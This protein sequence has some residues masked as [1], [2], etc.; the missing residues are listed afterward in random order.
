MTTFCQKTWLAYSKRSGQDLGIHGSWRSQGDWMEQLGL[1]HS[2]GLCLW[3]PLCPVVMS[4]T[5]V[6][7]DL[8]KGHW[9]SHGTTAREM[10]LPWCSTKTRSLV[11]R[12][13]WKEKHTN[14]LFWKVN[15]AQLTPRYEWPGSRTFHLFISVNSL[16]YTID[17][18]VQQQQQMLRYHGDGCYRKPCIAM[19]T[20]VAFIHQ[21]WI[22]CSPCLSFTFWKIMK[23]ILVHSIIFH[24]F[25]FTW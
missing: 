14:N 15:L 12:E 11:T 21:N 17:K 18:S 25:L 9:L 3:S 1:V 2:W 13:L 20:M 6:C 22:S 4:R 10:P 16:Q 19:E 8:W 5:A 24:S 7:P 23:K